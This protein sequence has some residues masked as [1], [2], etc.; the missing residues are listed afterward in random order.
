MSQRFDA[1]LAFMLAREGGFTD[2]PRDPGGATDHGVTLAAYRHWTGNP[3]AAIAE[4]RAMTAARYTAFYAACYWQPMLCQDLP[5]GVDLM[6][7]D[8]G[9]N[10]GVHG[11]AVLLQQAVGVPADGWIGPAT[12]AG[13]HRIAVVGLIAMLATMQDHYYR[14]LPGFPTYGRGWLARLAQRRATALSAAKAP[15]LPP[16]LP[17]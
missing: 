4:L 17:A 9:V 3:D 8:H 1:C 10:C 12:L 5:A 11:S 6:A 16:T 7:Y 14:G 13:V 2:D 15:Q